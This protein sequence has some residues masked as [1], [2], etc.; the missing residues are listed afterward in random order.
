MAKMD[1]TFL[2]RALA[3]LIKI[4]AA[5]HTLKTYPEEAQKSQAIGLRGLIWLLVAIIVGP[6]AIYL[7]SVALGLFAKGMV[8]AALLLIII[9]IVTAF[10]TIILGFLNGLICSIYQ[11]RLNRR[12]LGWIDLVLTILLI[13]ETVALLF[14]AVSKA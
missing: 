12:P 4:P 7:F 14:L 13:G 11:L 5:Y 1:L 3:D 2:L 8:I 6:L 9:T 10:Y